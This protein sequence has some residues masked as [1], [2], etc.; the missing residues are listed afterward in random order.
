M[1]ELY[2]AIRTDLIDLYENDK[3]KN[4]VNLNR[5]VGK[6]FIAENYAPMYFS[7][8][9]QTKTVFVML[10]P[11]SG[12]NNNYSFAKSDKSK[13]ENVEEFINSYIDKHTNYGKQDYNRLDN[14]D[15]KQ[16][17]FLLPFRDAGIQISDFTQDLNNK[18]LKLKAKESVLM[19]KL[20]LELI[21][22]HSAKFDELLR[23]EKVAFQNIEIFVPHVKRLLN[24]I[25]EIDRKYV[26]FGAKQF[27]YLFQAYNAIIP[28]T[29]V[30]IKN[31]SFAI[32]GLKNKVNASVVEI[33]H[34]GKKINTLIAHSFPRR[35]LPN[36]F[37][38]MKKYGELCFKELNN[39]QI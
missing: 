33:N 31:K 30:F 34:N 27:Y 11:G 38:K 12:M 15:L 20:Q 10:N 17:A 22:Y 37:V 21:P 26:I 14:F 3:I 29:F 19:N 39:N 6:E 8:N 9:Y 16:A 28:E 36:A 5:A 25:S 24:V 2:H 18:G 32:D 35:D 7:G 1:K 4:A 23:N 13:Y